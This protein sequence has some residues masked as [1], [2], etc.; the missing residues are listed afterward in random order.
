L[1][2]LE[3]EI[4]ASQSQSS[5]STAWAMPLVHFAL[6]ILEVGFCELFVQG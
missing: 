5:N 2:I 6:V 4:R 1:A 3:F